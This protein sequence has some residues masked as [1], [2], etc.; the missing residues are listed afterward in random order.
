MTTMLIES[1]LDQVTWH[2]QARGV[3]LRRAFLAA[4]VADSTFYR[5]TRGTTE[6]QLDTAIRVMR[7]IERLSKGRRNSTPPGRRRAC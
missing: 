7:T 3:D 4:G 5:A 1:Y 6:L 2:A